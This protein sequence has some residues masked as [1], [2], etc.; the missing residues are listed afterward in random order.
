MPTDIFDRELRALRR[1]RAFGTGPEL[2]LHERALDDCLERLALVRRQFKSALLIGCPNPDWSNRL[3]EVVEAV[4]TADP[5]PLFARAAGGICIAEDRWAPPERAYDLVLS[6]GTLDTVNDLPRALQAIRAS[7]AE[8][9]LFIGA[10]AGGQGL[11]QLRLAMHIADQAIGGSSP[12]V[13][14]R[15]EAGSLSPL[16]TAC[17]F[18]MPVVDVDRV[19]VSYETLESLVTDLRRMGATNILK[20]RSRKPLL[21]EAKSAAEAAFRSAGDGSRTVE[22]FEILHFAAWTPSD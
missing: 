6:I 5:G 10:I 15:V 4:E 17:G 2:F 14:P 3:K 11:P 22:T 12:H 8:D 16:L 21:R 9:S 7:L 19:Q 20:R 18:I 1:D 13:H